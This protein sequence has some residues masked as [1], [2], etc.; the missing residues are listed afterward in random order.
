MKAFVSAPQAARL[1]LT[2][3]LA[4]S[5]TKGT[6]S[7]LAR[8]HAAA[9]LE[10]KKSMIELGMA[11]ELFIPPVNARHIVEPRGL[12]I[13]VA[14]EEMGL[15]RALRVPAPKPRR[16]SQPLLASRPKQLTFPALGDSVERVLRP[17]PPPAA[18]SPEPSV[19]GRR[20]ARWL[21]PR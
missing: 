4:S 17:H 20:L 6:S 16:L 9:A 3:S 15:A 7:P 10:D 11:T 18:E 8:A 19:N 5:A 2:L 1:A 13:D 21:T 14:W 12:S